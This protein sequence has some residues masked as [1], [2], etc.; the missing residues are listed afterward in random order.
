MFISKLTQY[1]NTNR[2]F[3]AMLTKKMLIRFQKVPAQKVH[4]LL[5]VRVYFEPHDHKTTADLDTPKGDLYTFKNITALLQ[6]LIM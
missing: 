2:Q 1:I 4:L 3:N 5:S 6:S